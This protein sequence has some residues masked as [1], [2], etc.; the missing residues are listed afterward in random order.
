MYYKRSEN[1]GS[2]KKYDTYK[3]GKYTVKGDGA[4]SNNYIQNENTI[5]YNQTSRSKNRGYLT[6]K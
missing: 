6:I 3:G 4:N 1:G 5:Q 2:K